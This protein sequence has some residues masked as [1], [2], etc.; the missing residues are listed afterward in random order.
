MIKIKEIIARF[1]TFRL[2]WDLFMIQAV[3]LNLNLIVFDLTYLTLRPYYLTHLPAVTKFY[4]PFLG[5][6]PHRS[7]EDYL[8]MVNEYNRILATPD[9]H[10]KEEAVQFFSQKLIEQSLKIIDENPFEKAGLTAN[11]QKIKYEIKKKYEADSGISPDKSSS[12][13]AFKWF[14]TY[15]AKNVNEHVKFFQ[16][17]IF[18]LI[19]PNYYRH[20]GLNGKYVDEFFKLDVPF[21]ALFLIEFLVQWF[22]A[23]KNR[24]YVA[25]FLYPMYHWYDMLGLIPLAEFRFFRL[26][27]VVSMYILLKNSSLT[28]VGNDI[29]TRT[30]IYYTNIIK[31]E[32]TDMVTVR[33]L[34]EMQ[35]EIKSGASINLV[36]SAVEARR[37][38]LKKLIIDNIKK[39]LANPKANDMIRKLLAE[40]L[41]KSS[42]NAS[43]LQLVPSVIKETITKDIGL[44]IFDSVNEVI[45][46]KLTGEQ[47]EE[48]MNALIDNVL[49]D[50]ILGSQDGDF[51]RLS[52]DM[53]VEIIENMKKAVSVKK[54]V[55]AKL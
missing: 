11:F 27:R 21:F 52:E 23:V 37:E 8:K 47:G 45:N 4:D 20:Y 55:K 22:L 51:N 18:P 49:D 3:I 14:W 15:N 48:N 43:T 34:S 42:N 31:E 35:E 5:I 13:D 50:V 30:F 54:W 10:E 38:Q 29:F 1:F 24:V 6:E 9:S 16:E 26:F 53:T 25:W 41:V 7:T 28:N 39:G 19:E 44:A 32:L 36:T 12:K 17:E 40:A 33:I 2:L 46:S